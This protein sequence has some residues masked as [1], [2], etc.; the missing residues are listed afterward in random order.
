MPLPPRHDDMALGRDRDDWDPITWRRVAGVCGTALAGGA[1]I[2]AGLPFTAV[3][4]LAG[5]LA[6]IIGWELR[7]AQHDRELG[8][9]VDSFQRGDPFSRF[10][11]LE[12]ARNARAAL[13]ADEWC[14]EAGDHAHC[15]VH[16]TDR[17]ACRGELQARLAAATEWHPEA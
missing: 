2:V 11:G 6:G 13:D 12:A 15:L 8:A 5:G 16:G 3:T 4:I 10:V 14:F 7:G 17:D 9:L 1:C